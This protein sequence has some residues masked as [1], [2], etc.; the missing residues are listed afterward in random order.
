VDTVNRGIRGAG[1]CKGASSKITS[2][3]LR[4]LPLLHQSQ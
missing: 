1:L 3:Y 4:H 2:P